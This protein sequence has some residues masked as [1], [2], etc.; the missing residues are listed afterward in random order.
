MGRLTS[1]WRRRTAGLLCLLLCA[2]LAVGCGGGDAPRP[3]DPDK[4]QRE[5]DKIKE[6]VLKERGNK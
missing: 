4:L 6:A 1:M 3:T 5:S 2:P